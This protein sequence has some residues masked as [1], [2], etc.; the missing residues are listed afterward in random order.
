MPPSAL[1]SRARV[2]AASLVALLAAGGCVGE[3]FYRPES[4]VHGDDHDLA[5]IELDDQGELWSSKQV[6][7]ADRLIRESAGDRGVVLAIFI[8]GWQH[9]AS[10]NDGNVAGFETLLGTVARLEHRRSETAPRRVMGVYI[11]WRGRTT[12]LRLLAPFTFFARHRAAKRVASTATTE[13]LFRLFRAGRAHPDSTTVVI[14][15]SF[16][17][18][19]LESAMAQAMIGAL[20]AAVVQDMHQVQFPADLILL[21]N[22]ASQA[23]EAKQMVDIFERYHLKF[24]RSDDAGTTYEVPLVVSMTSTADLA[25][26]VLFPIGMRFKGVGNRFR[27]YGSESCSRGRQA[28]YFRRTAGHLRLLHSHLVEAEPLAAAAPAPAAEPP[29][30]D[31]PAND[32]GPPAGD[33]GP[34]TA[35]PFR[36]V[37]SYDPVSRLHTWS[38]DGE[39]LRYTI[40]QNP[41]SWNDTPYWIMEIPPAIVPNHSAIFR[42]ETIE[43]AG[44]L[45]AMAGALEGADRRARLVREDRVKPVMLVARTDGTISFLDRSQR[46]FEIDPATEEPRFVTCVPDELTAIEGVIGVAGTTTQAWVAGSLR[47]YGKKADE[48]RI[49]VT[50]LGAQGRGLEPRGRWLPKAYQSSAAAFDIA[51]SRMFAARADEPRVDVVDLERSELVPEPI[52]DLGATDPLRLMIYDPVGDRLFGSDGE[53]SLI[54]VDLSVTPPRVTTIAADLDSPSALAFDGTRRRLYVTTAGDAVLWK[55]ACDPSC[56]A[57]ARLAAAPQLG[58][59]RSLAVDARGTVWVSDLESGVIAALSPSGELIKLIERLRES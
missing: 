28:N 2:A 23:L 10:R 34:V 48:S 1:P 31:R 59:P 14:G 6:L 24:L 50:T 49:G 17:G 29:V 56:G 35:M 11:A 55:L 40:H 41:R 8:H 30:G 4:V 57:P 46:I 42:Q 38:A 16:G 58:H 21:V 44:T 15:H 9:D 54:E 45:I 51:R 47:G 26:R 52:A 27:P 18:L 20:G 13:T 53:A 32:T 7:A 19:I 5:F 37:H 25:T 33:S 36:L 3:R 12:P 39:K 22:P 43:F